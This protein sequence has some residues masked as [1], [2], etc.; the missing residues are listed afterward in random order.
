MRG[1]RRPR[2]EPHACLVKGCC[3]IIPGWKLLCDDHFKQLPFADRRAIAEAGQARAPH[4]VSKLCIAAAAAIAERE[5][6]AGAAA[7]ERTSRMMGERET[8]EPVP[9]PQGKAE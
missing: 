5:G 8:F 7:A 4:I 3:T 1:R 9:I 6:A 2:R